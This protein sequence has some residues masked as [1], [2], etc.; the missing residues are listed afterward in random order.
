MSSLLRVLLLGVFMAALDSAV[1]GPA[2]PAIRA[3]FGINHREV[4]LMMSAFVLFSLTSTVLM[5]NLSDRIGRR[6]IFFGGVGLFALGS[7]L[8]GVAGVTQTLD[9]GLHG[10]G[11][12]VLGRMLQGLGSGGMVPTASAVM[13]DVLPVEQQG[14]ALGWI[15]AV[16]GMAFV[17][18]PPLAGV[19]TVLAGWPWIFF[20]NLPLA[21]YL[22]LAGAKQL[23]QRPASAA[24]L[25]VK[26]DWSGLGLFFAS[27]CALLLGVTQLGDAFTGLQLWPWTLA[28]SLVLLSGFIG[29][30]RRAAQRGQ[31][32][33]VPLVLFSHPRLVMAYALTLG[34]GMSM[35]GI[36]FLTSVAIHG[37]GVSTEHAGFV[38]LPLVLCSMLSSMGSGRLLNRLGPR[39]LIVAGFA[40]LVL[41]YGGTALATWLGADLLVFLLFT[42]VVGLGVGVLVGGALR[43]VA[44]QEAPAE[45]RATAQ[46]L[47]NLFNGIGTLL[48]T[49]A[50]SV[51]A[52]ALGDAQGIGFASAY[53]G[54]TLVLMALWALA[55]RLPSDPTP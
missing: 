3:E 2:I 50:I 9:W 7:A 21:L 5:S 38:L 30:E 46:G 32:P 39:P 22:L 52:D 23:P 47:I 11:W 12:L 4:G 6:P 36:A 49:A 17:I 29:V 13:G 37:F 18:G 28:A 1:I 53:W 24:R 55:W 25:D 10:F 34:S 51:V 14:R 44:L 54:L 16:Y 42:A 20:I 40:A 45:M 19:L 33:M 26:L 8:I 27:L 31:R 43:T 48:A 15:G 41:G 35:G